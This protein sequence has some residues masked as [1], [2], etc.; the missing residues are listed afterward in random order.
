MVHD[1]VG[2]ES[3][4]AVFER[5]RDFIEPNDVR[6]VS[7]HHEVVHERDPWDALL[8]VEEHA[9]KVVELLDLLRIFPLVHL[10][11]LN[12]LRDVLYK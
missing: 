1:E 10:L 4:S 5:F 12:L 9:D 6:L 8:G 7:I 2:V 11:C 3:L